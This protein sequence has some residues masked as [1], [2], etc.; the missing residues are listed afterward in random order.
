MASTTNTQL[1]GTPTELSFLEGFH[2]GRFFRSYLEAVVPVA[3][4]PVAFRFTSPVDFI[5][6]DQR[7]ILTQGALRFEVF[8]GVVTPA[9]VWTAL[10]NIG[11]NRMDERGAPSYEAKAL[12]ETGGTFTG[13]T[14]V[15]LALIRT[16]A[17]NN[18]A[19]SADIDRR[20]RGLPP[21]TYYGRFSTLT[22]GLM[23][24]DDAQMV[25]SLHWEERI[26]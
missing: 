22:G 16:A 18:S 24:N 5:L 17:N 26:P 25:Y 3:G 7:L 8:G 10:P 9:G 20:E 11:V 4:P 6:W 2:A 12:I 15:D 19:S 1:S 23:V 14:M 13:G 21:G